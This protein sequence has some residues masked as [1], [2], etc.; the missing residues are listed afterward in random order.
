LYFTATTSVDLDIVGAGGGSSGE[1]S[2]LK[3]IATD[4]SG[5]S[6]T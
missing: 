2:W 5:P 6:T 3:A 4:P 1:I